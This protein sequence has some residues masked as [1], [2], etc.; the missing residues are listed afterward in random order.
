MCTVDAGMNVTVE[1]KTIYLT[2]INGK[3]HRRSRTKIHMVEYKINYKSAI[4]F[5]Q[6]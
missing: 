2:N 1:H 4:R 3:L 5:C 6:T